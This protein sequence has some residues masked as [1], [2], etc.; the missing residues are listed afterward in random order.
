M[1]T[2]RIILAIL[3][4]IFGTF[5]LKLTDE[6]KDDCP[7]QEYKEYLDSLQKIGEWVEDTLEDCGC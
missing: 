6:S 1:K 7:P 4:I 3:L 2:I 5:I